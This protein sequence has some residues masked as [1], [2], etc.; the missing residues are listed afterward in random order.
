MIWPDLSFWFWIALFALLLFSLLIW[1]RAWFLRWKQIPGL[2]FPAQR[3][4]KGIKR[5]WRARLLWIPLW[6]RG[7]ALLLLLFA[8]SRPQYA[9]EDTAEVEG[10]DIVVA[11]DLSGSM[12][13]VDIKDEE[14]IALQQDGKEPQDRFSIAVQVL[15]DFIESRRYDRVS[16]V[17]FG[18]QAFVQFPLTLDYGAMLR[19]LDRME[20]GDIEGSSTVIGNA[21]AM[22]LA[23]LK[24]S[25][26]KTK[27]I[28]LIT[29]GEDNGSNISPV[30]MAQ[31]AAEREISIFPILVGTEDQSRQPTQ[32]RDLFTGH[33]IYKKVDNPVN[34]A[35]LEQI[36]T[37]TGGS[38]YRSTD[39]ESLTN[40][41]HD[42]LDRFEKS[43]LVDYAAAE[44]R[45]LYLWFLLP[46][47]ALLFL[48]VLLSQTIL[49][50]FP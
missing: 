28:I 37:L 41:F 35:L 8:L 14:L 29:D 36:A 11:F 39:K 13:S 45:E 23:R 10:V 22:S 48:E 27:L 19:I 33:R 44:R 17:I 26:A 31:A 47:L 4:M 6:L 40:D 21:L 3:R 34:P 5:G 50:R 16:L 12:A 46:A 2:R 25:E 32:A 15:R 30:E 38:F 42:I 43:R 7:L 20:M 49:R 9:D 1:S 18:Q 24:E